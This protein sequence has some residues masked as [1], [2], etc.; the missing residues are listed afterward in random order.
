[1]NIEIYS[2]VF[3]KDKYQDMEWTTWDGRVV[4]MQTITQEHLSNIYWWTIIVAGRYDKDFNDAITSVLAK[5]F[6][7]KL[8][9]YNPDPR[10]K[11]ETTWLREQGY[12]K[13]DNTIWWKGE[14][15]GKLSNI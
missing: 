15:V 14:C 12:V 9:P 6:D 3:L 11:D 5:R 1:M 13:D 10:F 8:L 4:T 7:G 2:A